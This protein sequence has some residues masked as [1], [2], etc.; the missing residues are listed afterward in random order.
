MLALLVLQLSVICQAND[1]PPSAATP[2]NV[3]RNESPEEVQF[4]G[5]LSSE[6]RRELLP[7]V[8]KFSQAGSKNWGNTAEKRIVIPA[9]EGKV[10][11]RRVVI[12]PRREEVIKYK[13]GEWVRY[14]AVADNPDQTLQV[15]ILNFQQ[16]KQSEVRFKVR[17]TV[18]IKVEGDVAFYRLDVGAQAP[19]SVSADLLLVADCHATLDRTQ[20]PVDVVLKV[21]PKTFETSTIV[22]NRLGP[23]QGNEAQALGKLLQDIFKVDL[24]KQRADWEGKAKKAI[25]EATIS[26]KVKPLLINLMLD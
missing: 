1:Q 12:T 5:F 15:E 9:I 7:K 13:D 11:G 16:P 22:L 25:G 21:E 24:D 19:F 3:E 23:I 18:R 26:T 20:D 10:L 2:A 4:R 8:Q 17:S 14:Q 6:I